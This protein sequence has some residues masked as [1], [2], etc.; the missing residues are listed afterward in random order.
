MAGNWPR[1][2]RYLM[3][4]R[5][6]PVMLLEPL[7]QAGTLYADVRAN[8]VFLLLDAAAIPVGAELRGATPL[9]WRGMAPG[10]RKDRGFFWVSPATHRAIV[11]CE[12]AIDALS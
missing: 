12:S 7:A 2:R 1:V 3:E 5:K 4:E 8:A 10:S 9:A 11:L 6:L